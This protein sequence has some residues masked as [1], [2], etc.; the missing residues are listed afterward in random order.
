MNTLQQI[1][2]NLPEHKQRKALVAITSSR[3][4]I[5]G[6]FDPV[7]RLYCPLMAAVSA[8][9]NLDIEQC[10]PSLVWYYAWVLHVDEATIWR[11]S[12]EWDDG[13]PE[14]REEFIQQMRDTLAQMDPPWRVRVG[15]RIGNFFRIHRAIDA[16]KARV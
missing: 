12:E 9:A 3:L 1:I 8:I 16:S 4:I 10:G 13:T 5:F 14:D 6:W 15:N 11:A 7:S 2:M